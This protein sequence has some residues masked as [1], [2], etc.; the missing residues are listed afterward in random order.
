MV[1]LGSP[2]CRRKGYSRCWTCVFKSQL[3]PSMRPK[4]LLHCPKKFKL[5][6]VGRA[7]SGAVRHCTKFHHDNLNG[8]EDSNFKL[9]K[10]AAARDLEFLKIKCSTF[11]R[12]RTGAVHHLAKCHCDILNS[13]GDI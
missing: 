1:V 12:V 2:I 4:G 7:K 11:V 13:C 6:T 5:L 9:F 8:C 10:M 3:L